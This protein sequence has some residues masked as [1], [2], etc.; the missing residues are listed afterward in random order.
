MQP[1]DLLLLG[2]RDKVVQ[3]DALLFELLFQLLDA[4]EL[5]LGLALGDHGQ[6]LGLGL[7]LS[8]FLNKF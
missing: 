3:P 6:P 5:D 8:S 7:C 4:V 1:A 2:R